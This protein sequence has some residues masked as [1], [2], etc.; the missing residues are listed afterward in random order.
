MKAIP[1]AFALL[2]TV[3]LVGVAHAECSRPPAPAIPDGSSASQDEMV[4]SQKAVKEFVK[5]TNTFLDCVEK[6]EKDA[7]AKAQA[8]GKP[9]TPDDHNAYVQRYNAGVD[10]MQKVAESFNTQ[11]RTYLDKHKKK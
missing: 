1:Y 8:D 6:E 10:D 3:A 7:A 4:K 9:M 5:E 11:L 2:S